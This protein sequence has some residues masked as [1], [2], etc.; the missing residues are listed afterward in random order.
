MPLICMLAQI[1]GA[2]GE[3]DGVA[4]KDVNVTFVDSLHLVDGK[5]TE[6]RYLLLNLYSEW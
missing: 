1:V 6:I 2:S 3:V 5:S 4:S